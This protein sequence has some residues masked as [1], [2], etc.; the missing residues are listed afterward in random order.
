MLLR[1]TIC[2][3]RKNESKGKHK[4]IRTV[5]YID[6]ARLPRELMV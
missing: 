2:V 5:D 4:K 6:F 3:R 1:G